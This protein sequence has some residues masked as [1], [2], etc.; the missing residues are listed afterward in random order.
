MQ[1]LFSV[2]LSVVTVAVLGLAQESKMSTH[3]VLPAAQVKWGPAPP[4]VP[5]GVQ[6][7]VVS[8]N[9]GAAGPF[10]I[11]LKIP[12]GQKIA[13]HWHPTEE[14]VTVISGT[15]GFGMGDKFDQ[16]ALKSLSAGG[17]ALMPAEMRHFAMARTAVVLQVH[18]TG[19]F[20]L[21]YVNPADDPS[22]VNAATK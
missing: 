14:N 19:P 8:G 4:S 12:A 7:A 21:N 18:G 10:V 15:V 13:P 6:L 1:K 5:K 17:F 20:V 22:K 16:A 2:A 3:I 9:P 11:R